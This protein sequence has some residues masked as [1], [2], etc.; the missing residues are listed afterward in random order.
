MYTRCNFDFVWSKI[1]R[2]I[3]L[4]MAMELMIQSQDL[5]LPPESPK[6][7]FI[8]DYLKID[9]QNVCTLW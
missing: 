7:R 4:S 3:R 2:S 1:P 8:M 6:D 9:K 5:K